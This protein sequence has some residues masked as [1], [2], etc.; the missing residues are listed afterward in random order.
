VLLAQPLDVSDEGGA[1]LRREP[2]VIHPYATLSTAS[3]YGSA[4][5]SA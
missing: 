4:A 3:D 1:F 2:L 5:P